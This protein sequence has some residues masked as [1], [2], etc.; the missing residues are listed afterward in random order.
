MGSSFQDDEKEYSLTVSQFA[1]LCGTT[2]DTLRHY[3]EQKII[4]PRVDPENGYHYYSPAQI[5]SFFFITTMRQAGCSIQE[6]R[7]MI[8]ISSKEAI[9]KLANAKILDMQ[10]ELFL[11]NKKIS[12]LHLGM[13]ILNTCEEHGYNKVFTDFIPDIS[14][15]STPIRDSNTAYHVADIAG[16]I[17]VHLAKTSGD[18]TLSSFPTGVTMSYENMRKKRYV[19]NNIVSLSFLPADNENTFSLPSN[20]VVACYHGHGSTGIDKIYEKMVSYI[21]RHGL[22][23]VSDLFIVSLINLYSKEKQHTYFKYL[24]ICV[25]S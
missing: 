11:I 2:R 5:S 14:I 1:K 7:D 9:T 3:Y 20:N 12:A 6:I 10:R 24:F 21:K 23:A 17:S 22:T 18:K 8:Y 16:D 15:S 13:W 25:K 4:T 19:Y